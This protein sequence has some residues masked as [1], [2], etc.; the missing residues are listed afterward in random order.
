MKK[1]ITAIVAFVIPLTLLGALP[2]HYTKD[3]KKDPLPEVVALVKKNSMGHVIYCSG[4]AVSKR[5]IITASHCVAYGDGDGLKLPVSDLFIMTG[6]GV[7]DRELTPDE[8]YKLHQIESVTYH[9]QY[10]RTGYQFSHDVAVIKLKKDLPFNPKV[11]FLDELPSIPFEFLMAG[12]GVRETVDN[13]DWVTSDQKSFFLFDVKD[14]GRFYLSEDEFPNE[15]KVV[16]SK[17]DR[18]TCKGDSGGPV[19]VV[20]DGVR[21]LYAVTSTGPMK[22]YKS[23]SGQESVGRCG[24]DSR[25]TILQRHTEFLKDNLEIAL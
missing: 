3:L 13:G 6:H 12:F 2:D 8:V 17:E 7:P 24:F 5:E 25:A 4:T 15:L 22:V 20:K 11:N 16:D 1:S 21:Y 18:G 10:G 9:P 23:P 14:D 19:F